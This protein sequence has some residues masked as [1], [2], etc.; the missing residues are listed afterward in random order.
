MTPLR[1]ARTAVLCVIAALTPLTLAAADTPQ[2]TRIGPYGG[3]VAAFAAAQPNLIYIGLENGWVFLSTD[4]GRTWSPAGSLGDQIHDL[5]VD[6]KTPTTL[7]AGTAYGLFKSTDRG[8]SWTQVFPVPGFPGVA[9]VSRVVIHPKTPRVLFAAAAAAELWKSINGGRTWTRQDG[10]PTYLRALAIDPVRPATLYASSLEGGVWKS[11]NTGATWS[12]ID[13][14]LPDPFAALAI[15]ID[16]RNHDTVFLV[17]SWSANE[18]FKSTNGGATWKPSRAGLAGT[19]VIGLAFDPSRRNQIYALT[20]HHGVYKSTNGGG[21]WQ[22]AASGLTGEL[23]SLLATPAGL[24]AGGER[25]AFVSADRA[26]SWQRANG[27]LSALHVGGLAFDSQDPPRLY[28]GSIDGGLFKSANGGASWL[29]LDA[30][31]PRDLFDFLGPVAI[32][33]HDPLTVYAMYR[34]GYGSSTNGGRRWIGRDLGC[35]SAARMVI[36]ATT[37][38]TLYV[39]GFF[40]IAACGLQ[41][42]ACSSYRV[43]GDGAASCVRFEPIGRTGVPVLA[44]DPHAPGTLYAVGPEG[45]YRSPDRAATWTLLAPGFGPGLLAF[46][47]A[48]AGVVYGSFP[49]AVG[50]SSDGGA[51]WALGDGLPAGASILFLAFDPDVPS[52]LYATTFGG[53]WKSTDS[54]AHWSLLAAA[55]QGIP[56]FRAVVDPSDP[57]SLYVATGSASVLLLR[58]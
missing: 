23:T 33:P 56:L 11:V 24:L 31:I 29:A 2:W 50:R 27:G 8:T 21:L 42:N 13:R 35:L 22:A 41:P 6:P 19:F 34:R 1:C 32:D 7:Y 18:V 36:D 53:V 5:A 14:G 39:N 28:A 16:P 12:R 45:L 49:G 38:T 44:A 20:Q 55:P 58:Q 9:S 4:V 37:P 51:T 30:E 57:A 26:Q 10:A 40:V 47:P 46:D 48:T 15:A 17:N 43:E 25:G 54:G 3:R 52:T